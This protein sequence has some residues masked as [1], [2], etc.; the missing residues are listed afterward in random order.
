MMVTWHE[1]CNLHYSF[2]GYMKG[3]YNLPAP[4]DL[5]TVRRF[6]NTWLILSATRVPEDHLPELLHDV[7]GWQR[8]FPHLPYRDPGSDDELIAL[9]DDLRDFVRGEE[10]WPD[11]LNR[12]LSRYPP[13]PRVAG[14]QDAPSLSYLPAPDSG[15]AGWIL[16]AIVT[17][18][19]GDTWSR[20]KICPDCQWAFYD[21]TRSRTKIWCDMLSGDAG[22]RSCGTIAKVRRYRQRQVN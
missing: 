21:R 4:G 5:E 22:G 19:A 7:A 15:V 8:A 17:A 1:L 14:T 18:V 12:W 2:G 9:R 11:T 13:V 16:A 10:Q 3:T 20:L 6:L